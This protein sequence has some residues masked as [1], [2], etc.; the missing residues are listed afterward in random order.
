MPPVASG[1]GTRCP[2]RGLGP[3]PGCCWEVFRACPGGEPLCRLLPAVGITSDVAPSGLLPGR[4]RRAMTLRSKDAKVGCSYSRPPIQ[5]PARNRWLLFI[6]LGRLVMFFLA[7]GLNK[8]AKKSRGGTEKGLSSPIPKFGKVSRNQCVCVG[9]M[10][11]CR[12]WSMFAP[13]HRAAGS[14][15]GERSHSKW[16]AWVPQ[17]Q[18]PIFALRAMSSFVPGGARRAP[19]QAH[20]H[21]SVTVTTVEE[22]I[23]T[24]IRHNRI[25]QLGNG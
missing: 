22:I 18:Y 24:L 1:A 4:R 2:P 19:P 17:G 16:I 23:G 15:V 7:R 12:P 9:R 5:L 8:I 25:T 11:P 3:F 10:S 20:S 13:R 6:V 14:F 21:R